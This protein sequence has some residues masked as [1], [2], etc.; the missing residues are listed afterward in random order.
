[1]LAPSK[2]IEN[3]RRAALE[4]G[5]GVR[6]KKNV[7]RPTPA[8]FKGHCLARVLILD[9]HSSAALAFV[10]SAGKAGHWVAVGANAGAFAAA[11]LSRYCKLSFSYPISTE[12]I[13]GFDEAIL[14]F[15]NRNAVDL[16]VPVT[17]WTLLP[18][19][20][21]R[22]RFKHICKVALPYASSI[23]Q[24]SDKY[25]TLQ[26][27]KSLGIRTPQTWLIESPGDLESLRGIKFPLVVKDRFS[28]RWRE[29]SAVFGGVSYAYSREDLETQVSQRLMAAGDVLVQEFITGVGIGFSCFIASGE[30]RLPFQWKR[31]REV[32][33]RGSASSC[34]ESSPLDEQIKNDSSQLIRRIGFEGIAMIEYKKIAAQP[35]PV[36]MEINGR[37]WGSIALPIASGVDYPRYL[38]DWY[39]QGALPPENKTYRTGITCRR[40]VAEL[41]HLSNVRA[42]KPG[43]WPLPYPDFWSTLLR[44]AMPWYPG[45][46]YDDL[47]FSDPRPG[48]SGLANWFQVRAKE[49]NSNKA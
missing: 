5:V 29:G 10:R 17:D 14:D 27:A 1:M 4:F 6:W 15:V 28:L 39:L 26:I 12:N 46:R 25:L 8:V 49:R 19:S 7:V 36:L 37:P 42:G 21:Y 35:D 16:V 45:M 18:L 3:R 33:P 44:V 48:I 22:E 2:T 9:G 11:Q 40:M 43:N 32:D 47:W 23:E 13:H 34:R 38:I 31:V 41:T 30:V 20:E 24:A